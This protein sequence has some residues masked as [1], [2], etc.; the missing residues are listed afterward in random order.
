MT[1]VIRG[2]CMSCIIISPRRWSC[3]P[4]NNFVRFLCLT[5]LTC[6]ALVRPRGAT[7]T[8]SRTSIPPF[9]TDETVRSVCCALLEKIT[10]VHSPRVELP[11][12]HIRFACHTGDQRWCT[13]YRAGA[14]VNGLVWESCWKHGETGPY[15][16]SVVMSA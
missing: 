4:I 5:A 10:P 9:T 12:C 8:S 1:V 6:G 16:C 15:I 2:Y 13:S 7:A 11:R 14:R 3:K